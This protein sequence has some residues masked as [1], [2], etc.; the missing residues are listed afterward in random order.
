MQFGI[1]F[2]WLG[3]MGDLYVVVR[4]LFPTS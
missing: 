2:G 3:E 1:E 4:E